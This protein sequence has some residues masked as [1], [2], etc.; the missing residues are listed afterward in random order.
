MQSESQSCP[1]TNWPINVTCAYSVDSDKTQLSAS[2]QGSTLFVLVKV[3]F[4]FEVL[5][6]TPDRRQS[7]ILIQSTN[8]DQ[9]SLE[10]QSFSLPFVARL[11][12]NG[13]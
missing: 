11:A 13:N 4:M 8:V 1:F 5:S 6:L 12:T 7:K 2:H 3:I 9:T 10:K